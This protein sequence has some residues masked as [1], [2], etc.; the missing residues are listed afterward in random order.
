M[1][2]SGFGKEALSLNAIFFHFTCE[3]NHVME[4]DR[5]LLLMCKLLFHLSLHRWVPWTAQAGLQTEVRA[6]CKRSESW[7]MVTGEVA[8][9]SKLSPPPLLLLQCFNL[10][11]V[12]KRPCDL[13]HFFFFVRGQGTLVWWGLPWAVA[14]PR[15]WYKP[16]VWTLLAASI[17][18]PF[19]L[20]SVWSCPTM[21]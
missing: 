19:P 9:G 21:L 3:I 12:S 2:F 17:P 10:A 15:D 5:T 14:S 4:T 1:T 13:I 16:I 18:P 7:P 8:Q 6:W 20:L 11:L